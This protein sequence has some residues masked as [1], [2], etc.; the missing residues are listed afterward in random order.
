MRHGAPGGGLHV[1]QGTTSPSAMFGQPI[2]VIL[3][4][5]QGQPTADGA[6]SAP[7][8]S[9]PGQ[10]AQDSAGPQAAAVTSNIDTILA[11]ARQASK[12]GNRRAVI[13]ALDSIGVYLANVGSVAVQPAASGQAVQD[14]LVGTVRQI[15]DVVMESFGQG[16]QGKGAAIA[17]NL[18]AILGQAQQAA[19][20]GNRRGVVQALAS[21]GVYL[22][23]I[24]Y[25]AELSGQPAPAQS[26]SGG[27]DQGAPAG[28]ADQGK[29]GAS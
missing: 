19:K 4:D 15:T 11:E 20:I 12:D 5:R 29:G 27:Q 1:A 28:Q 26:Q 18:Q 22:S 16:Q 25:P 6:S 7:A 10:A 2:A 8:Q 3:G 9:A 21:I 17:E 24:G 13:Q 23:D 14:D